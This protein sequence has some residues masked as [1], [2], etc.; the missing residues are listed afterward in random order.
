MSLSVKAPSLPLSLWSWEVGVIIALF[1]NLN[2][3]FYEDTSVAYCLLFFFFLNQLGQFLHLKAV[4]IFWLETSFFFFFSCW[5]FQLDQLPEW[6][7]WINTRVNAR[8]GRRK[9][10]STSGCRQG[11]GRETVWVSR[12]KPIRPLAAFPRVYLHRQR[13]SQTWGGDLWAMAT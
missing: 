12:T 8:A 5:E 11:V 9:A 4:L 13:S 1:F 10:V 7:G 2:R 3:D 6:N